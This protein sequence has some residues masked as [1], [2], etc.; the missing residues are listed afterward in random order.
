MKKHLFL[1]GPSGFGKSTIIRQVLGGRL[2]MAGGFVTERVTDQEGRLLGFD[3]YPAAHAGGVEGFQPLR[4]MDYSV[5]PPTTDNEVFRGPG[6]QILQ[7]AEY[8]P[9]S[10]ID[11]FGGFELLIPQFRSALS[12][13]LSGEQPCIGVLKEPGNAEELRRRFGLGEKYTLYTQRLREALEADEDTAIITLKERGD[14]TARRIV[15]QWARE[16]AGN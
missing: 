4:F 14:I 6:V 2:A 10:V 5:T 8:Y 1:T 3:L 11:E 15:E 7:E 16:Y 13:F 12:D 9:F